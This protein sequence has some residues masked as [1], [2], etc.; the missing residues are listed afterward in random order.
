MDRAQCPKPLAR[1]SAVPSAGQ[2]L[3]DRGLSRGWRQRD[4]L[5]R[6]IRGAAAW[7]RRC[8]GARMVAPRARR[9]PA[10]PRGHGHHRE[11]SAALAFRYRAGHRISRTSACAGAMLAVGWCCRGA[12]PPWR[13]HPDGAPDPGFWPTARPPPWV[14]SRAGSAVGADWL[15]VLLPTGPQVHERG[16]A[17]ITA[18][19]A[20]RD[21]RGGDSS[22]LADGDASWLR[23]AA[24][25]A[26]NLALFAGA[27][28]LVGAS[29]CGADGSEAGGGAALAAW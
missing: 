18:V 29:R 1:T 24:A 8:R 26:T 7:V 2:I 27:G 23:T 11:F 12:P 16:R 25:R 10:P 14:F 20:Q 13:K 19:V 4:S 6:A 15:P 28:V 9:W 22:V 21:H 17:G 3:S 5:M